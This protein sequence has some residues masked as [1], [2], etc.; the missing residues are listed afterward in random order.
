MDRNKDCIRHLSRAGLLK[1]QKKVLKSF[2]GYLMKIH[3]Y[4]GKVAI[5]RVVLM[6]T[7]NNNP[8]LFTTTPVVA[9]YFQL[10][11]NVPLQNKVLCQFQTKLTPPTL[12]F[13]VLLLE[14]KIMI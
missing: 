7:T 1:P 10:L 9:A 13:S 8:T 2:Q 6:I 14:Y 5:D 11:S 3:L 12:T 4:G